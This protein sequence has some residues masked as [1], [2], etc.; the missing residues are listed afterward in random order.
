MKE[1]FSKFQ[2]SFLKMISK[3]YGYGAGAK[4]FTKK[5]RREVEELIEL[6]LASRGKN[7]SGDKV[8]MYYAQEEQKQ[9]IKEL[10]N[11]G[12]IKLV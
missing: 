3:G 12:K 6:G 5:E 2:V 7:H 1:D 4:E 8:G 9:K 11:Q 10:F